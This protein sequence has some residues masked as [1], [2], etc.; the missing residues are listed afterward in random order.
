MQNKKPF[1]RYVVSIRASKIIS[2]NSQKT[3]GLVAKLMVVAGVHT[4]AVSSE[5]NLAVIH[6]DLREGNIAEA[7]RLLQDE[8]YRCN[9]L[10]VSTGQTLRDLEGAQMKHPSAFS[11]RPRFIKR[12][13]R[14]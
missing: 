12:V 4:V 8:G 1:A 14:S 10:Q 13:F 5:E 2:E 3:Q 9:V 6:V 7:L 11:F